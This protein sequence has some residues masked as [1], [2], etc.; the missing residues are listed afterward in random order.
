MQSLVDAIRSTGASNVLM[1]GGLAYSNDLTKW[2]EFKPTD[3]NDDLVASWHAYDYNACSTKTCW[4]RKIAPVA[5]V[6]PVIAGEIGEHDCS[7][8]YV[9]PLMNW[10]DEEATSYLAWGWNTSNCKGGPA[11]ISNYSGRATRFGAGYE[12]H[13]R[14]LLRSPVQLFQHLNPQTLRPLAS[15]YRRRRVAL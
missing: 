6:V 4:Q 2:L 8:S 10:L 11:L 3:P 12:E 14:K 9:D 15:P 13:L 1:L 5:A 7:D